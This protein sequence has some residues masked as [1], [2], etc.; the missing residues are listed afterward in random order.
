M[1]PWPHPGKHLDILDTPARIFMHMHV[2]TVYM[3]VHENASYSQRKNICSQTMSKHVQT[4]I[5]RFRTRRGAGDDA[6][7]SRLPCRREPLHMSRGV[8]QRQM[9]PEHANFKTLSIFNSASLFLL[10]PTASSRESREK[11]HKN[12]EAKMGKGGVLVSWPAYGENPKTHPMRS[13]TDSS[14]RLDLM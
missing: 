6:C 8:V 14:G 11:D 3:H 1:S 5:F 9:T 2:Y 7:D 13:G 4:D 12:R 10:P